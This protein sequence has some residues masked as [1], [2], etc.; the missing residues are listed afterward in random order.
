M[1]ERNTYFKIVE[2]YKKENNLS[3]LVYRIIKYDNTDLSFEQLC[4]RAIKI[5]YDQ[6]EIKEFENETE[7]LIEESRDKMRQHLYDLGCNNITNRGSDFSYVRGNENYCTS[8]LRYENE[9][10]KKRINIYREKYIDLIATALDTTIE[11]EYVEE[12][13]DKQYYPISNKIKSIT[14]RYKAKK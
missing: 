1:I 7:R 5:I 10:E 4:N 11:F 8:N 3:R 14:I 12:Y 2:L 9:I 13:K 6:N